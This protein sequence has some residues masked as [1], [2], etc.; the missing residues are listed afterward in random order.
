MRIEWDGITKPEL[1]RDDEVIMRHH[2]ADAAKVHNWEKTLSILN[3]RPDL[4]NVTRLNG[5]ALY[6]PLHQAAH[7]NASIKVVQ[8]FIAMG[9]WRTLKNADGERPVDIA[10]RKKHQHLIQLLEPVYKIPVP[11]DILQKIQQHFHVTILSR[12][13]HLIKKSSIRLPE[14]GPLLEIERPQMWF[15]IPWMY[16]GFKCWLD[17]EGNETKLISESWCRVV[18]GSGQRHEITSKESILVDQGFV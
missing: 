13:E 18:G 5:Q 10:K 2:L 11:L 12:A 1:L 4:I 17:S 6:T 16:G 9:A 15:P 8:Q 7:G 3:E 14:L